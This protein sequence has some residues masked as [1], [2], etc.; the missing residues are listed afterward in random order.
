MDGWS[1]VSV[2]S[3]F[4]FWGGTTS[5]GDGERA[6]GILSNA[7]P[8]EPCL[9]REVWANEGSPHVWAPLT[10]TLISA[11]GIWGRLRT[12]DILPFPRRWPS[13]WKLE[14]GLP[15]LLAV[16][17]WLYQPT[18]DGCF[19]LLCLSLAGPA[20]SHLTDLPF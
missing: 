18:C 7:R 6:L 12:A 14:E 3:A 19:V 20:P 1:A 13:D 9:M 4:L 11:T 8:K 16:P 17:V 5:P 15:R 10:R 2:S